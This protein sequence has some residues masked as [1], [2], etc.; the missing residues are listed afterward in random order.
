MP[1]NL[2]GEDLP[3]NQPK[4]LTVI[5]QPEDDDHWPGEEISQL[6]GDREES[7]IETVVARTEAVSA[8]KSAEKHLKNSR[9]WQNTHRAL[10]GEMEDKIRESNGE[11]SAKSM[12]YL[13]LI[14][15]YEI[16][17]A[18]Y[19]SHMGVKLTT[20]AINDLRKRGGLPV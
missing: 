19:S 16:I 4:F 18:Q 12:L 11:L 17:L 14:N 2:H 1:P 5:D 10:K 8:R 9:Y 13:S 6:R 7:Q 3:E 20:N 15:E